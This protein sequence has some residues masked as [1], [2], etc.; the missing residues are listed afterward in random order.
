MLARLYA[1][2]NFLILRIVEIFVPLREKRG[3]SRMF[4]RYGNNIIPIL[5]YVFV[6]AS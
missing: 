1:R 6:C 5:S 2:V 4:A 3:N